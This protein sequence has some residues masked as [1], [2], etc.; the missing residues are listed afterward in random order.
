M[1]RIFAFDDEEIL[2]EIAV[3]EHGLGADSGAAAGDVGGLDFGNQALE[4]GAEEFAAKGA[5]DLIAGHGRVADKEAP[6]PGKG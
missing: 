1:E 4:R 6:E 5:A 2:D 3:G